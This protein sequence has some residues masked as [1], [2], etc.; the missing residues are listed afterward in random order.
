[1]V[2]LTIPG[3]GM[4]YFIKKY[5]EKIGNRVSR[6]VGEGEELSDFNFFGFRFR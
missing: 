5:V 2:L 4:S 3:M 6:I 1:M